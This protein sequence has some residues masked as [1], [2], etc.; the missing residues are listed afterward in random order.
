MRSPEK[1]QQS[2]ENSHKK[3]INSSLMVKL[4][5]SVIVPLIPAIF[6]L[7]HLCPSPFSLCSGQGRDS[8]SCQ[9]GCHAPG[10][11]FLFPAQGCRAK[12]GELSC[13][14][15]LE[16]KHWEKEPKTLLGMSALFFLKEPL[17]HGSW[18]AGGISAGLGSPMLQDGCYTSPETCAPP[19]PGPP[20]SYSLGWC[21]GHQLRA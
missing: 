16:A 15:S 6:V 1:K 14:A 11:L 18:E 17:L 3:V 12:P 5:S 10:Q 8:C 4:R 7:L 9:R 19:R 2:Q 20:A 13:V 21:C